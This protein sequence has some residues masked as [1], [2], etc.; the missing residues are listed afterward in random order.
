ML[1]IARL[2]ENA[3]EHQ[4]WKVAQYHAESLADDPSTESV[5]ILQHQEATIGAYLLLSPSVHTYKKIRMIQ[6]LDSSQDLLISMTLFA[7]RCDIKYVI[8]LATFSKVMSQADLSLF[9]AWLHS[10]YI[11]G[12]LVVHARQLNAVSY[13]MGHFS[14]SL[15]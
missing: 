7:N 6:K 12:I 13:L 2:P 4:V 11:N 1:Q 15:I 14:L 8:N 5:L 9:I 3:D 10:M